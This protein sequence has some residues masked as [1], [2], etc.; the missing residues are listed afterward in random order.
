M[1]S[2]ANTAHYFLMSFSRSIATTLRGSPE[3]QRPAAGVSSADCISLNLDSSTHQLK[4][5][6]VFEWPVGL[7]CQK[8]KELDV[9]PSK[10]AEQGLLLS[11]FSAVTHQ[12]ACLCARMDSVWSLLQE[13]FQELQNPPGSENFGRAQRAANWTPHSERLSA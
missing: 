6:S 11:F 13:S 4:Y 8:R 10:H 12:L 5:R 1:P 7:K 2:V 3:C 9:R